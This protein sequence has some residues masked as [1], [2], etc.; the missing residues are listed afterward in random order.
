MSAADL[1]RVFG[2]RSWILA[3]RR[4]PAFR[5]GQPV[6]SGAR[7]LNRAYE[8]S[9]H[10]L[11]LI[12]AGRLLECCRARRH[13]AG[14]FRL[15]VALAPAS[16]FRAEQENQP[17]AQFPGRDFTHPMAQVI[18]LEYILEPE[19]LGHVGVFGD[20]EMAPGTALSFSKTVSM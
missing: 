10:A 17:P 7:A 8:T 6:R 11:A 5:K 15:R 16:N 2:S 4:C 1:S 12:D 3:R 14:R 9:E 13:H 18:E 19:R 20:V